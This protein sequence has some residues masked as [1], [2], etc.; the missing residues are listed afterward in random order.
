MT[1]YEKNHQALASQE[2]YVKLAAKLGQIKIKNVEVFPAKNGLPTMRIKLAEHS[3]LIHSKY[4]P[5]KEAATLVNRQ[6]GAEQ[7]NFFIL[8]GMGLGYPLFELVKKVGWQK[9]IVVI[10]PQLAFFKLALELFDLEKFIKSPDI[11]FFI[12]API[13]NI[14]NQLTRIIDF[15]SLREV[16]IIEH[17]IS[18]QIMAE[19][20]SPLAEAVRGIFVRTG[21]NL[22][23]LMLSGADYQMNTLDNLDEILK[24][25][26]VK[27][28]F[29]KF[30]GKPGFLISAGPS[31]DKNIHLLK[32]IGDRAVLICVETAFKTLLA[33]DIKPHIVIAADPL[34]DNYQHL[35]GVDASETY[36]IAEPMTYPAII[37]NYRGRKFITTFRD[38]MMEW[39]TRFV[40]DPGF[41]QAW[42]SISTMGFDLA[43]KLGC[44]PIIMVGQDLSFSGNRKYCHNTHWEKTWLY[45]YERFA[46]LEDIHEGFI[47]IDKTREATGI[48]GKSVVT[49]QQLYAYRKWF[50]EEVKKTRARCYNATEGGVLEAKGLGVI[51]LKEAVYRFCR[52]PLDVPAVLA[53]CYEKNAPPEKEP[54]AA[55]LNQ[56]LSEMAEVKERCQSG[57][58]LAVQLGKLKDD[59]EKSQPVYQ[60]MNKIIDFINQQKD[61][62]PFLIMANQKGRYRFL[63]FQSSIEGNAASPEILEKASKNY[64]DFYQSVIKAVDFMRPNFEAALGKVMV[65]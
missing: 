65:S 6:A 13:D 3:Q 48:D 47:T 4:D 44:D 63:R 59:L 42:G 49:N 34:E 45:D 61:L 31:L 55:A 33:N 50:E 46:P 23:T 17:P 53:E 11:Y 43:R 7:A 10:E 24:N 58:K 40:G 41:L 2:R 62:T 14:T 39:L 8:M 35:V 20:F 57:L 28:I 54:L 19:Y 60:N 18:K 22:L 27:S 64:H 26:P 29:N 52:E 36:L 56:V 51:S 5:L 38:V 21:G 30:T 1:F 37:H 15:S 32:G 25:P 16:A 12:C 9:K